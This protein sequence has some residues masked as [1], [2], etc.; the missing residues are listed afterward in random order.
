MEIFI[1]GISFK[2]LIEFRYQIKKPAKSAA[3]EFA[4]KLDAW[5]DDENDKNASKLLIRS[6]ESNLMNK[7]NIDKYLNLLTPDSA[8]FIH[9]SSDYANKKDGFQIEEWYKSEF[10]VE[11]ID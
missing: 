5:D 1:D 11:K 6:Y 2:K 4:Y 10:K 9:R 7:E 8:F 3:I